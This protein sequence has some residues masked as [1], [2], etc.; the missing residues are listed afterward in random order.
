MQPLLEKSSGL[1]SNPV[2]LS[3]GGYL[4]A[5]NARRVDVHF[6]EGI[7]PRLRGAK[8]PNPVE[9]EREQTHA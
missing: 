2:G 5:G 3:V 6:Q 9:N 1:N 4:F 8:R 7:L